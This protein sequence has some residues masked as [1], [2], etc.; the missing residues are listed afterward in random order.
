MRR[1]SEVHLAGTQ[2]KILHC[3]HFRCPPLVWRLCHAASCEPPNDIRQIL[4][5]RCSTLTAHPHC[6]QIEHSHLWSLLVLESLQTNKLWCG[7]P[8]S[9]YEGRAKSR[10]SARH[11]GVCG[12]GGMVPRIL[13]PGTGQVTVRW[14]SHSVGS[15]CDGGKWFL[16]PE[17]NRIPLL[18]SVCCWL[19][20]EVGRLSVPWALL[21]LL[22]SLCNFLSHIWNISEFRPRI[23]PPISSCLSVFLSLLLPTDSLSLC[24]FS[25]LICCQLWT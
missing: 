12:G 8:A 5:C 14:R 23:R 2:T 10:I 1:P 21:Y 7:Q 16:V 18:V 19:N 15:Y 3:R 25:V 24:L 17:T 6:F 20:N 13:N 22:L 9:K 4:R 11:E